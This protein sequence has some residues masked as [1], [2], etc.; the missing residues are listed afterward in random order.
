[1]ELSEQAASERRSWDHWALL[2]GALLAGA[3]LLLARFYLQPDTR[4]YGTHQQLGMQPCLSMEV[5]DL[6]CP[7]CGVTTSVTLAAHGE[8]WASIVNQPFGFFTALV[9]LFLPLWALVIHFRGG[10]LTQATKSLL[11][12]KV[13]VPT[14]LFMALAWAYKIGSL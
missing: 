11:T 2:A 10:H 6:P 4:G 8:F 3:V 5:L 14:A 7:G 13:V 1:M 9:L 12:R